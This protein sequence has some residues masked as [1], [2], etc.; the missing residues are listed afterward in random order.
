MFAAEPGR[1]GLEHLFMSGS[2]ATA[3]PSLNENPIAAH[4]EGEVRHDEAGAERAADS[5]RQGFESMQVGRGW[6]EA[7]RLLDDVEVV[8]G[9]GVRRAVHDPRP[10]LLRDGPVD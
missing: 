4:V 7:F 10:Y 9:P 2:R 3:R 6:R 5:A 1:D 8:E